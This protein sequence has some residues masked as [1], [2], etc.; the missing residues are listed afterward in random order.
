MNMKQVRLPQFH[1][2]AESVWA[3]FL[4][5]LPVIVFFLIM[6]YSVKIL[7]IA[8]CMASEIQQMF[9][10]VKHK[11]RGIEARRIM[12]QYRLSMRAIC[13]GSMYLS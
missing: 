12:E 11:K 2:R 13:P 7:N 6:F 10:Q 4:Q 8:W 5:A 9:F 3:Q 1:D